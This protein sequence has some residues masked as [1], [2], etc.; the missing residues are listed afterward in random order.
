VQSASFDFRADAPSVAETCIASPAAGLLLTD[1]PPVI[2]VSPALGHG[3]VSARPRAGHL[4]RAVV[5]DADQLG[6]ADQVRR[7]YAQRHLPGQTLYRNAAP[8]LGDA[9]VVIDNRNP[10]FGVS[11]DALRTG[12]ATL[13]A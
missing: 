4:S 8:P 7:R 12:G 9:D 3:D 2:K 6:G 1:C 10:P 11:G 13:R 5:R